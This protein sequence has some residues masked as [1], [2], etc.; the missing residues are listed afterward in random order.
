MHG[1]RFFFSNAL[2]PRALQTHFSVPQDNSAQRLHSPGYWYFQ[3]PVVNGGL[4]A[5]F[6]MERAASNSLEGAFL[7]RTESNGK[8]SA[9]YSTGGFSYFAN[10][11]L[12]TQVSD[13]VAHVCVDVDTLLSRFYDPGAAMRSGLGKPSSHERGRRDLCNFGTAFGGRKGAG[14]VE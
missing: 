5:W 2:S 10:F 4:P 9:S 13:Y 8:S 1:F 12:M 6:P 14:I 11:V 7:H 3:G